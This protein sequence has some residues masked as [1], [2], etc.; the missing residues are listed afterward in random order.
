MSCMRSTGS[1]PATTLIFED[2]EVGI[3]GAKSVTS[4]VI[5]V[6]DV[7]DTINEMRKL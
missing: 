7:E 1:S 3:Q 2:S 4:N 6:I 5:E